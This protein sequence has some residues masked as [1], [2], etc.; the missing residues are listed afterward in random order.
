MLSADE[1][2]AQKETPESVFF[3]VDRFLGH[4]HTFRVG[5]EFTQCADESGVGFDFIGAESACV[6]EPREH[7]LVAVLFN[8]EV[9][10][11]ES[12]FDKTALALNKLTEQINVCLVLRK[13]NRKPHSFVVF[14]D[15]LIA[16]YFFDFAVFRCGEAPR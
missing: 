14:G 13:V 2:E 16:G 12:L 4:R 15:F 5:A 11:T 8:R 6:G 1:A 10:K 7:D 3:V 9:F